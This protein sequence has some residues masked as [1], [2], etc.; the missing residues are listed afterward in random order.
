MVACSLGATLLGLKLCADMLKPAMP[1]LLRGEEDGL[2]DDVNALLDA[3][4]SMGAVDA[5][6]QAM[7]ALVLESMSPPLRRRC[8]PGGK[9]L[10]WRYSGT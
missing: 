8:G 5:S 3:T 7:L 10:Q 2:A 9:P 4:D 6:T 1:S